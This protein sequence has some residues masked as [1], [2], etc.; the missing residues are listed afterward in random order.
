MNDRMK[1]SK[2][3]KGQVFFLHKSTVRAC[4]R[5]LIR[6]IMS[7]H[8]FVRIW[9]GNN[10]TAPTDETVGVVLFYERLEQNF[11]IIVVSIE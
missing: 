6:L 3:Q 11:N 10:S 2:G 8:P 1:R 4:S 9:V 7:A 5:L